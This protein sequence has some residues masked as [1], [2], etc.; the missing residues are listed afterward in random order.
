MPLLILLVGLVFPRLILFL[1]WLFSNWFERFPDWIVGILGFIFMPYTLLWYTAV[2]NFYSGTWGFFQ[3]IFLLVAVLA[4]LYSLLSSWRAS[5][6]Q[7]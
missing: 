4:D 2:L 1:L 7:A 3:T 5:R 6:Y